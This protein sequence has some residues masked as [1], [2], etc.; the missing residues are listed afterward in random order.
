METMKRLLLLFVGAILIAS[1]ATDAK[2][3][4]ARKADAIDGIEGKVWLLAGYLPGTGFIPIEPGHG[5]T[6]RLV[7]SKDGTFS[8]T[9][10]WN[11]VH[12]TW[13]AKGLGGKKAGGKNHDSKGSYAISLTVTKMTKMAP[14]GE[15]ATRFERDLIRLLKTS[16]RI[17]P[18]RDEFRLTDAKGTVILHYVFRKDG[19]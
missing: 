4:A 7:F 8:G 17:R 1:C 15:V 9:T 14:P 5:T 11:D 18:S 10:G 3:G 16:A 2:P 6:A 19:L 12:G 13:A